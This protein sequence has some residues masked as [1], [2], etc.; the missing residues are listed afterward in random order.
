MRELPAECTQRPGL[1][2]LSGVDAYVA[3]R[4]QNECRDATALM[5]QQLRP[6]VRRPQEL[7]T[8]CPEASCGEARTGSWTLVLR[9]SNLELELRHPVS[10]EEDSSGK[11]ENSTSLPRVNCLRLS[12]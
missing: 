6:R 8:T 4:H 10:Q 12:Y 9:S 2:C 7:N 5:A 1:L 11:S 3:Y